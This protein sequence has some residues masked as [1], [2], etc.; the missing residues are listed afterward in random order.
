M[1]LHYPTTS[2]RG[3]ISQSN[4]FYHLQ[5]TFD[6]PLVSLDQEA[7]VM[8]L[9]IPLLQPVGDFRRNHVPRSKGKGRAGKGSKSSDKERI[10]APASMPEI[11][12][13]LTIG[14]NTTTRRLEALSQ[15][16]K[17]SSLSEPQIP[18]QSEPAPANLLAV[19]VC[20]RSFPEIM[21]SSLPL[22][23]ATAAASAKSSR[24]RLIEISP[25]SEAEIAQA[26]SQPRVGVLGIENDAPGASTLARFVLEN[27]D[28]VDIPWLEPQS[29]PVYLPLKIQSTVSAPKTKS[30]VDARKRK[31]L[32][33]T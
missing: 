11:Y 9:L 20:R 17:P 26:L 15:A 10:S 28:T 16:Q 24:T 31:R 7:A 25:H 33:K 29:I 27:I 12:D 21:T 6:R 19:L 4:S 30:S 32:E 2:L 13:N 22:L 1:L 14:F 3:L 5:L 8:T 18:H 23:I